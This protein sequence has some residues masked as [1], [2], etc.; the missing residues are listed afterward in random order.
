MATCTFD[1][2]DDDNE[3]LFKSLEGIV[4][5]FE[6]GTVSKGDSRVCHMTDCTSTTMDQEMR[7]IFAAAELEY[8]TE[9]SNV[10]NSANS[11]PKKK[12]NRK[13]KKNRK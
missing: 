8:A 7:K 4:V 9:Q 5:T 12:A 1:N 13:G 11:K 3:F 6:D 10:V 2:E